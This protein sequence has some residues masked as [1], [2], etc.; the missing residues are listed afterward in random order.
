MNTE[1]F[2]NTVLG[3]K[4]FYCAANLSKEK[5]FQQEFKETIPDVIDT[6]T[7]F[8]N[9]KHDVYFALS[10]F[11]TSKRGADNVQQLKT[12]FLDIDCGED[13]D[14]KTQNEGLE[15]LKE[16]YKKY[17]I[18]PSIIV[19][20]GR[21]WHVYWVLD[22][23]CSREE[24]I[25]VAEQFRA[26][27]IDYGL[28]I[29]AQVTT[30][31]ARVLRPVG[32]YNYKTSPRSPVEV[33]TSNDST[34]SLEEFSSRLPV[35]SM[36]VLSK[37]SYSAIDAQEME[38]LLGEDLFVNDFAL[39]VQKNKEQKGCLQLDRA[40][41]H[42]DQLSY[43]QWTDALSIVVLDKT[44]KDEF[45]HTI[46]SGHP[47]YTKEE[48]KS[49]AKGLKHPHWC[50]TFEKNNPGGC[51]G[52]VH[53]GKVRSPAALT[54]KA[55]E[56]VEEVTE[57][58][59][60]KQTGVPLVAP[61]T[62]Y[63]KYPSPY[64]R[65][66]QGGIGVKVSDEKTGVFSEK[67]ICS[68]DFYIIRRLRDRVDGPSYIF[69]HHT[70]QE[71]IRE[72][73]VAAKKLIGT[74]AFKVAMSMNDI[75]TLHPMDLMKYV[76]AWVEKVKDIGG[77]PE[78]KVADQ[79]GW[80]EGNK[81][82]ILGDKEIFP[83]KERPN[84]P[85]SVTD[86]YFPHFA[87]RGTLEE[88][89]KIPQFF[90][91][92]GF[93]PHQY[94]FG[95]SFAAPLMIFAPKIA[96]SI[97]HLKSSESGF[98][99]STGQFA[100]A[101]VWGDPSLVVQKGDDT[102]A[103]VWKV[104]ETYKNIVVY[105]DELSNKDGEALSNFAYDVSSGKQ[106]NRL[107]GN[108]GENV[109]R[110]RGKPWRTLVPTSGNTSILETIA[111]AYRETPQ[112]EAQRVLEAET[113]VRLK[114]DADTTREGIELNTLLENHYGHAGAIYI[115]FILKNQDKTEQILLDTVNVLIEKTGLTAQNR[116][117]LWQ[118]AG[119]ITGLRI[120]ARKDLHKL[121]VDN[122][123]DWVCKQLRLARSESVK[124]TVDINDIIAAYLSDNTRNVL[125]LNSTDNE[126]YDPQLES[127]ITPE[128]LPNYK[129]IGRHDLDTNVLYLLP[130]PFKKW[131]AG[132]KIDYSSTRRMIMEK[133]NGEA[134]K[135]RLGVNTNIRLP[136]THVLR[137]SWS[138]EV[139]ED[140]PEEEN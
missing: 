99:K 95:L 30:D 111:A 1:Q 93:E 85:S 28:K 23:P 131:C 107:K 62:T 38:N 40:I 12:L 39:L 63:P 116:F 65:F 66:A 102:L 60:L 120:A 69:R 4:G 80:T 138:E 117:W 20:S 72:F 136:L 74:E 126:V 134:L 106:R 10:T 98:G 42:Q 31:A 51:E 41:K 21:G 100:G 49:V 2:L 53:K 43:D 26:A 127:F 25:P 113:M 133:M 122:L 14:Y 54:L 33:Y 59:V 77:L 129:F 22:K 75:F 115:K 105:V 55:V 114:E 76:A 132:R 109:E 18:C 71:G 35:A 90:D 52:C 83:T 50:E 73:K 17:N 81:S 121:N 140:I 103:S 32:T 16:F 137:M 123:Q 86:T 6:I 58:S 70:K 91:K 27:C 57:T 48:T 78:V 97:F 36:P 37:Q 104:A 44:N 19:N 125:R 3:E 45:I 87:S 11:V 8:S 29:D 47:N 118:A 128:T 5:G 67:Q 88:W 68:T 89:K 64:F 108:S 9:K 130:V 139:T 82:F 119:V 24:W 15:A 92:P 84:Y 135:Y 110:W 34:I 124:M 101:S 46:S 61:T 112:G 94:M 7:S 13:K 96:G 79:F 56:A